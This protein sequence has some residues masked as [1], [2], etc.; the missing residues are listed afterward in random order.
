MECPRDT[1]KNVV[2]EVHLMEVDNEEGEFLVDAN[3]QLIK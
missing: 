3:G 2:G 1:E